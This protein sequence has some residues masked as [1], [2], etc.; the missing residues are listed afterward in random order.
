MSL[1]ELKD[2]VKKFKRGTEDLTILRSVSLAV[3]KGDFIAIVGPSGSGKSTLMNT[4]GLLDMPTSGSYMLDGVATEKLKDDQLAEV[5]N[6]KIG[7]IFQQFNL[8]P[9]LT[10]IENVELPMIYA[11]IAKKERRERGMSMLETLGMGGRSHHRPSELSGGQQQR[12]AI[13]RA[14]A[15]GPAILLADE[16]TGALD[17]TTGQE[18]LELMIDLNK[19]GN[20]IVLITH[21]QHIAD[22]AKRVVTIRDGEIVGDKRN[23]LKSAAG[24]PATEVSV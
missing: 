1:I 24:R 3:E 14:L 11:G 6:K 23:D 22:N 16:P 19:A 12:V 9:R 4:I 18:V 13:A 8:L 20:T 5:R 15:I 7:F 10:A 17:S 2:I 21:D